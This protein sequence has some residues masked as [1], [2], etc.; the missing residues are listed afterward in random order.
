[1]PHY[2]SVLR[3]PQAGPSEQ[4]SELD[5]PPGVLVSVDIDPYS[6]A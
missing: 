6:F 3:T 5:F 2:V 1:M 4:R